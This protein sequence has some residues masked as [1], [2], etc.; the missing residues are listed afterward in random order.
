MT[1]YPTYRAQDVVTTAVLMRLARA[2]QDDR[3]INISADE[4]AAIHA[5]LMDALVHTPDR[6]LKD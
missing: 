4:V 5:L 2:F 6:I 3:G 1:G